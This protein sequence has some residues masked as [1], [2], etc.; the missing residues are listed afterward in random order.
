MK[1]RILTIIAVATLSATT[2]ASATTFSNAYSTDI[3]YFGYPDTTSYGETFNLASSQTLN[4][5][6]FYASSG[7]AGNMQLV[8]A[9]WDGSKAVGPALY[10]SAD[11]SYSGGTQT[12]GF[13]NIDTALSAGSYI[14]Y[15]TVAGVVNPVTNMGIA[16]SN[17][18][19]GLGGSFMYSNSSGTDPLTLNTSW[20]NYSVPDM[21]YTAAFNNSSAVPEPASLALLGLGLAGAV[22]V[23]R[24]KSA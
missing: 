20:S 18:D 11:L 8:I 5:W 14:A 4:S 7:G 13:S 24:R 21:Q 9:G 16:G 22:A 15:I 12:L 2:S 10:Q 1:I 6:S 17:T 3:F 19:G 23:R